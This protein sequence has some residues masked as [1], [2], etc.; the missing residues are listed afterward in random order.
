MSDLQ[1]PGHVTRS[2][3]SH[4]SRGSSGGRSPACTSA[5]SCCSRPSSAGRSSIASSTCR[6]SSSAHDAAQPAAGLVVDARPRGARIELGQAVVGG[7][8]RVEH[9]TREEPVE[10]QELHRGGGV[11]R[12]AVRAQVRLVRGAAPQRRGPAGAPERVAVA[13]ATTAAWSCRRVRGCGRAR[14]K[15]QPSSRLIVASTIPL[16][17]AARSRTQPKNSWRAGPVPARARLPDL[18]VRGVERLPQLRRHRLARAAR[19]LPRRADA[20]TRS[21]RRTSGPARASAVTVAASGS[22]ADELGGRRPSRRAARGTPPLSSAR[23]SS[24]RRW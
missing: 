22:R 19:V 13:R 20:S 18:A 2:T 1:A 11:D 16:H 6:N 14:E 9:R 15:R 7:G 10:E 12:V 21:S 3:R 4:G 24:S 8:E 23:R 5:H 17:A